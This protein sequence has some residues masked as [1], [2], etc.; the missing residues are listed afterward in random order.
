MSD[1]S[2]F[3]YNPTIFVKRYIDKNSNVA[4]EAMKF[5]TEQH[6]K[7]ELLNGSTGEVEIK[8]PLDEHIIVGHIDY[9]NGEE[10]KDYKFTQKIDK[11]EGYKFQIAFYQYLVYRQDNKLVPATLEMNEVFY[12]PFA[13][14]EY[15]TTGKI[16]EHNFKKPTK[17][18]LFKFE[19][20]ISSALKQMCY[21]VEKELNKPTRPKS[22]YTKEELKLMSADLPEVMRTK[23]FIRNKK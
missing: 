2:N 15:S 11:F 16:L 10:I 6:K 21:L 5:G 13:D 9:Y 19:K 17:E 8:V 20:K 4:N 14:I 7:K 1:F 23:N 12:D 3:Y 18:I 22:T